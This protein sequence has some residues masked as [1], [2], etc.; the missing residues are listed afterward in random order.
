MNATFK[1]IIEKTK[2]IQFTHFTKNATEG[3]EIKLLKSFD[4][5]CVKRMKLLP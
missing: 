5:C 2:N 3:S 4:K 1:R